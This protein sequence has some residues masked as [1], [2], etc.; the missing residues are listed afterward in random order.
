MKEC[1]CVRRDG[2]AFLS[3]LSRY[4]HS[5]QCQHQNRCS[6]KMLHAVKMLF[7][8]LHFPASKPNAR[9]KASEKLPRREIF[10]KG[11]FQKIFHGFCGEFQA[12]PRLET[13]AG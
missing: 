2:R 7:G 4:R 9:P 12:Q 11:F 1:R 6:Q 10:H 13:R 5:E 3:G 8:K